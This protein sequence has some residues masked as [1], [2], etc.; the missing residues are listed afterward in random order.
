MYITINY[1]SITAIF[2]FLILTVVV[3]LVQVDAFML[4]VQYM[5]SIHLLGPE[6]EMK[7][8]GTYC[9]CR[10]CYYYYYFSRVANAFLR[11]LG[12]S[13]THNIW[14]TRKTW[15]KFCK[16]KNSAVTGLG[17]GQRFL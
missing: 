6:L 1:Y 12:C 2:S 15:R 14:H 10:D 13:K 11:G 4:Y 8:R 3:L 17:R 16:K 7:V 9:F 5:L